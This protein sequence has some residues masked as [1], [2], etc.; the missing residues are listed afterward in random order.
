MIAE[1][2]QDIMSVV[3]IYRRFANCHTGER[4]ADLLQDIFG[5][6]ELN[7]NKVVATV[8]DNGSN[9]VKAFKQFGINKDVLGNISCLSIPDY[10]DLRVLTHL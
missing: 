1:T 8:T 9:F 10:L 7:S 2:L 3:F 4:I 5:E 6:F